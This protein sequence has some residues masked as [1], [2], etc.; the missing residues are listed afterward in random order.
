MASDPL[1][2]VASTVVVVLVL[3][4]MALAVP[5][6]IVLVVQL[7]RPMPESLKPLVA[8]SDAWASSGPSRRLRL[9]LWGQLAAGAVLA[10]VFAFVMYRP[11]MGALIAFAGAPIWAALALFTD[12]RL[13]AAV[14][15]WYRRGWVPEVRLWARLWW[16]VHQP[17]I[18]AGRWWVL[19]RRRRADAVLFVVAFAATPAVILG[20]IVAL[21]WPSIW[22]KT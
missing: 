20:L 6:L 3:A 10:T 19:C 4:L 5:G 16:S 1:A 7:V 13:Y 2:G 14:G 15:V 22:P 9:L 12:E 8:G 17:L 11:D 18:A 21:A